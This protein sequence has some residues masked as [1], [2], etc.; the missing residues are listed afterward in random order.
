[1]TELLDSLVR[2]SEG[3]DRRCSR[4]RQAR[5]WPI[6]GG[7]SRSG[8]TGGLGPGPLLLPH[9]D[10]IVFTLTGGSGQGGVGSGHI[11]L[12]GGIRGREALGSG[13]DVGGVIAGARVRHCSYLRQGRLDPGRRWW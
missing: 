6:G 4:G 9:E 10:N 5:L 3:R 11:V 1:M 8:V 2:T 7:E 13:G 12:S